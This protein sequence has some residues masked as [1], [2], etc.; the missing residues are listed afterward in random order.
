MQK[1]MMIL[2]FIY[3]LMAMGLVVMTVDAIA[4]TF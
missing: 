3:L 4:L 1:I 2:G